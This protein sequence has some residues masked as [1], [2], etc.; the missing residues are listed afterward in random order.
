MRI[1]SSPIYMALAALL[2]LFLSVRV[3]MLR[4]R[5]NVGIG[6]GG[7]EDLLRAIR[8]QANFVEY[9]PIALLLIL[10]ADLV[11]HEK[12]FV[13]ILGIALLIA[14]VFHAWGVSLHS[15]PSFGRMVGTSLTFLVLIAGAVLAILSFFNI[16]V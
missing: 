10:A 3:S 8:V 12:I 15:G 7:H 16:R 14:R 2:L 11:G 5:Y 9:V 4:R 6:D 1:F 13:H